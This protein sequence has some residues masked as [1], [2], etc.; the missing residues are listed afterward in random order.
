MPLL[1][2]G[3]LESLGAG[4]TGAA[5]GLVGMLVL[6]KVGECGDDDCLGPLV[7]GA[8]GGAALGVPLG[9]FGA[10]R[11]M[12]VRG[13]LGA[14]Y[15]G[16][17]AGGGSAL[18][19]S[20]LVRDDEGL[21]FLSVPAAAILGSILGFELSEALPSNEPRSQPGRSTS[22]PALLLVPTAGTTPRGGFIGGLSGR[23]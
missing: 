8:M 21:V 17:L 23:F 7:F 16:L 5:G 11:L 6:S 13:S 14:S 9:V 20:L 22:G 2:R 19:L 4:V 3:L 1:A 10:G 18:A 12:G 15:L